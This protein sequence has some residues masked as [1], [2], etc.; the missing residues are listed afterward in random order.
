MDKGLVSHTLG[1]CNFIF[2][3]AADPEV[4]AGAENPGKQLEQNLMATFNLLEAIRKRNRPTRLMFASTS[5]IYGEPSSI[6]TGEDYGPLLPISTYGA[7]KLGC[8]AL[9][10]SYTQLLPLQVAIFRFANVVGPRAGHGVIYDFIRKLKQNPKELEVLGDG[11][12]TKSYVHI[13]DCI[14]A[15]SLVVHDEFWKSP[16]EAYNIGSE[17]QTNVRTIASIVSEAMGLGNVPIRTRPGRDG[18]AWPGDVKRMRLDISK[19]K[20]KGWAP[21]YRST[22]TIRLAATELSQELGAK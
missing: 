3:L 18:R 10:A 13:D 12:Q 21:R 22:E 8:E 14:N 5:T 1:D 15:F 2:H 16:V 7:T 6:P 4:R 19:I 17:D 20:K 11:T 9:A